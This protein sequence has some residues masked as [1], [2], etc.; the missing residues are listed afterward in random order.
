MMVRRSP[1]ALAAFIALT[2]VATSNCDAWYYKTMKKFGV[3]KRDILVK[4]LGMPS[5]VS[6]IP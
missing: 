4:T 5:T 2:A 3:E 6:Q 1:L